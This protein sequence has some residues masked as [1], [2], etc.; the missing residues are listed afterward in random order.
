VLTA[1]I[2]WLEQF[3]KQQDIG[4][5]QVPLPHLRAMRIA[6]RKRPF[7]DAL[8]AITETLSVRATVGRRAG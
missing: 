4:F 7:A 8:P 2:Q 1:E 6:V 3:S 5:R